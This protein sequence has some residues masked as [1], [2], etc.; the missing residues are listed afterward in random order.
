MKKFV[1]HLLALSF[2]MVLTACGGGGSGGGS[3]GGFAFPAGYPGVDNSKTGTTSNAS[4]Q[5]PATSAPDCTVALNGDSILHGGSYD[6]TYR[7]PTPP[8]T[9]LH[10]ARPGWT[11]DDQSFNGQSA[12]GQLQTFLNQ[13]LTSRVQVIEWGVNDTLIEGTNYEQDLR[14]IVARVQSLN[15]KPLITGL[16]QAPGLTHRDEFDAIARRVASDMGAEFADWG[17]VQ[18]NGDE[19]LDHLHPNQAYSLRLVDQLAA[20]LDR[21]AP[22]CKAQ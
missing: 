10:Q 7:L 9:A 5:L 15:K 16:I 19:T 4:T 13:S 21:I 12:H 14:A 1:F 17:A 20:A 6:P 2:S 18:Q 11:I 8:A 3:F 22:E